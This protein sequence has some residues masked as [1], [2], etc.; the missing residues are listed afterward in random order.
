MPGLQLTCSV[1]KPMCF[2]VSPIKF[3]VARV[4]PPLLCL[5]VCRC[6]F[7]SPALP[8]K[9]TLPAL[10]LPAMPGEGQ[11]QLYSFLPVFPT[12][13]QCSLPH[14]RP[15]SKG[16]LI[17]VVLWAL[18]EKTSLSPLSCSPSLFTLAHHLYPRPFLPILYPTPRL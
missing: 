14:L 8:L 7:P 12:P 13:L 18:R 3:P 9:G 4:L 5:F 15:R 17:P 16:L 11:F 2:P 6:C 10:L 1:A